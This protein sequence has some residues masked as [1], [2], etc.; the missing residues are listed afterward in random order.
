MDHNIV[1]LEER[2]RNDNV[3]DLIRK[4]AEFIITYS[5]FGKNKTSKRKGDAFELLVGH[6]L[7]EGSSIPVNK[8]QTIKGAISGYL[9]RFYPVNKKFDLLF[10]NLAESFNVD[11]S[12]G[13]VIFDNNSIPIN[14]ELKLCYTRKNE[15]NEIKFNDREKLAE[16]LIHENFIS[17]VDAPTILKK[18]RMDYWREIGGKMYPLECKNKEKTY[19]ES[20]DINQILNYGMIIKESASLGHINTVLNGHSKD[21]RNKL[22][23]IE[24]V[25][26]IEIRI[27][28]IK[29][30]I[31]RF[32]EKTGNKIDCLVYSKYKLHNYGF[33]SKRA[34]KLSPLYL[35]IHYSTYVSSDPYDKIQLLICDD[36]NKIK[37]FLRDRGLIK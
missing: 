37:L 13:K 2:E 27:H 36:L 8:Q 7:I 25:Y 10:N 20:R 18:F 29:N 16:Y 23:E 35:N 15:K 31:L 11:V 34:G 1:V 30:W 6:T 19:L 33:N 12:K 3:P 9:K 4:S 28:Y 24:N 14:H 5:D 32:A 21:W 26:G 17:K 22:E